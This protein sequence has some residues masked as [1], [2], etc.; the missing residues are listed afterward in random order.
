MRAGTYR[1]TV[2]GSLASSLLV[3]MHLPA[4]HEMIEHGATPQ[5]D[6]LGATGVLV[7]LTLAGAWKLLRA[8]V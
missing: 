2:L 6:V 7:I 4:V 8:P 5:A 1:L 3:G